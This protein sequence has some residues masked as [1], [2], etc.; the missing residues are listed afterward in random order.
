M[1]SRWHLPKLLLSKFRIRDYSLIS[2]LFLHLRF[3]REDKSWSFSQTMNQIPI[4][5]PWNE[6]RKIY[7]LSGPCLYVIYT[8]GSKKH[9]SIIFDLYCTAAH[10]LSAASHQA[11]TVLVSVV[12][13]EVVDKEFVE[14]QLY[15]TRSI[16]HNSI[17]K[18]QTEV[19]TV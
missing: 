1:A 3:I 5:T 15:R 13:D 4:M 10:S 11:D 19:L 7:E 18:A 2:L 14:Y 16:T 17:S 12:A 9:Q 8:L 6:S